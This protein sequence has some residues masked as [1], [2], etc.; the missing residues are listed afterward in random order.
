MSILI[1]D[2]IKT[3]Q[4]PGSNIK[5]LK[6]NTFSVYRLTIHNRVYRF[7]GIMDEY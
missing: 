4:P 1:D 6:N 5:S 2:N 3:R 7:V